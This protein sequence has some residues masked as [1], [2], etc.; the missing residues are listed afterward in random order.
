MFQTSFLMA[1]HDAICVLCGREPWDT[2]RVVRAIAKPAHGGACARGPQSCSGR[3]S[4]APPSRACIAFTA[5]GTSI[6]PRC[7]RPWPRPDC[8][9][10]HRSSAD[11]RR[12]AGPMAKDTVDDHLE[13]TRIC[14]GH[15]HR[16]K[17]RFSAGAI[18]GLR[19]RRLWPSPAIGWRVMG[20]GERPSQAG[21]LPDHFQ[22][23]RLRQALAQCEGLFGIGTG[24]IQNPAGAVGRRRENGLGD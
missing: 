19:R 1:M 15:F 5:A 21:M 16:R 11:A 2:Q 13:P 12:S 20:S 18:A 4:V 17:P 6:K 24:E 9:K 14:H 7:A 10:H 22:P 8:R 3:S 23:F